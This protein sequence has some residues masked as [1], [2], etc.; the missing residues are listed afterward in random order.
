QAEDG[1][2]DF[3][4]T[5][6]QTCALPIYTRPGRTERESQTMQDQRR[7]MTAAAPAIST[8]RSADV[9]TPRQKI[10][11]DAAPTSSWRAVDMSDGRNK[12]NPVPAPWLAWMP[13]HHRRDI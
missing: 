4:V 8:G 11:P 7:G 5:G 12:S 13:R 10:D 9:P 1:I 3:H 2:R 6:V